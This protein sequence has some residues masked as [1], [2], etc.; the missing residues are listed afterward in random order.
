MWVIWEGHSCC[1]TYW[2]GNW[3]RHDTAHSKSEVQSV[4]LDVLWNCLV[5][6]S[7]ASIS[8][9]D[10]SFS[11]ISHLNDSNLHVQ[12]NLSDFSCHCIWH[13]LT[14]SISLLCLIF[15][16][17]CKALILPFSSNVLL[18]TSKSSSH[19]FFWCFLADVAALEVDA[20]LVFIFAQPF[21]ALPVPCK[22]TLSLSDRPHA[23]PQSSSPW[24]STCCRLSVV[25]LG[26]ALPQSPMIGR[27]LKWYGHLCRRVSSNVACPPLS[28]TPCPVFAAQLCASKFWL[29]VGYLWLHS[30]RGPFHRAGCH[31]YSSCNVLAELEFG[32]TIVTLS[33][34]LI[35]VSFG[36]SP[37]QWYTLWSVWICWTSSPVAI[38]GH[39]WWLIH[40]WL[41]H[42]VVASL[43]ALTLSPELIAVSFSCNPLQWYTLWSVRIC[44][45]SSP[46]PVPG[47]SWWLIHH[48]I[49]HFVV[50]SFAAHE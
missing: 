22:S 24:L 47:H 29:E 21:G 39:S 45:T 49:F 46:V 10:S 43:A 41:L 37:L 35:A 15:S 6:S 8:L 28:R 23:S 36:C 19:I 2:S 11:S 48:W 31:L 18:I 5:S 16:C 38:P 3:T 14:P 13:C 1:T 34:E 17:G 42:L 26:R 20:T 44:W 33:P 7:M 50:A 4:S 30:F 27:S 9:G 40:H 25:T 32:L 12:S